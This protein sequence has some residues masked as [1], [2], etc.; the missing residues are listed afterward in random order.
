[1]INGDKINAEDQ[2]GFEKLLADDSGN[3]DI[4][5]VESVMERLDAKEAI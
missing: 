2:Y 1:M 3:Q 4:E 5:R